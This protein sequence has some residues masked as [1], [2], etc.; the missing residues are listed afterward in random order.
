MWVNIYPHYTLHMSLV[1]TCGLCLCMWPMSLCMCLSIC[2]LSVH[3]THVFMY[4]SL[5]MSLVCTCALC[6]CMWPMSLCM[7]LSICPLSVHVSHVRFHDPGFSF[8]NEAVGSS[9][10][11]CFQLHNAHDH[12]WC[13]TFGDVERLS[14][15]D[16]SLISKGAPSETFADSLTMT[17]KLRS[18][19]DQRFRL[20][21]DNWDLGGNSS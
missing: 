3:V 11:C 16:T 20:T 10:H 12:Q 18:N 4:V 9:C 2:P 17:L 1:C 14:E 5:H 13:N 21:S 8:L 19:K 15:M 6:L 7:C